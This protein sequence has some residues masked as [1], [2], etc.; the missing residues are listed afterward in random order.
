MPFPPVSRHENGTTFFFKSQERST[1]LLIL[2]V[3]KGSPPWDWAKMIKISP[4]NSANLRV[5]CLTP[6]SRTQQMFWPGYEEAPCKPL[7]SQLLS[8]RM[9]KRGRQINE[10]VY[11]Q[12]Q[13]IRSRS[14]GHCACPQDGHLAQSGEVQGNGMGNVGDL[15]EDQLMHWC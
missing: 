5:P 1:L 7:E 14:T 12:S 10:H 15:I 3:L 11:P 2:S 9:G 6:R 8:S 4:A 13:S